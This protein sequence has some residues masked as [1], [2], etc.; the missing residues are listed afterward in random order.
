[1]VDLKLFSNKEFFRIFP[2]S[3]EQEKGIKTILELNQKWTV[4]RD[5]SER[6][7]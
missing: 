3:D 5:Q 7:I 2:I 4:L 1:M 6:Y